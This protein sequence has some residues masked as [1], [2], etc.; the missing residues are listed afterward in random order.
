MRIAYDHSAFTRQA[1]G[2][3][4]RYF[5][6]L[7]QTIA[8]Y[9]DHKINIIAPFHINRHLHEVAP[10]IV[11]GHYLPNYP[12]ITKPFLKALNNGMTHRR[13]AEWKPDV[14]HETYFTPFPTT[15]LAVPRV[16]TIHDMIHEI[17]PDNFWSWDKTSRNKCIA[18]Q[19]ADHVICISE[20]TRKDLIQFFDVD[21]S[22]ISVVHHAYQRF[23]PPCEEE[24]ADIPVTPFI[25]FVGHRDGYKNFSAMMKAYATSVHIRASFNVICFGGGNFRPQELAWFE[26]L[27]I[28]GKVRQVSGRDALL[29]ALYSRASAFVYPSLYE[30]FGLPPLEAMAHDC[31]VVCSNTSS[32]PEVVADAGEY[33]DP[34]DID[35]IRVAIE[36][37]LFA[38]HE[39]RINMVKKGRER[40]N[41]F[42][43]RKCA[44]QTLEVYRNVI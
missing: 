3:V 31:I 34:Q 38:S 40:L 30:G 17:Y 25:L 13:L 28:R 4:S 21:T 7:A 1:F 23:D 42:S 44:E 10:Y 39:S 32:I 19:R 37:V 12:S 36:K 43:W 5:S 20:S 9:S 24:L 26:T 41:H 35:S 29:G 15:N 16:V 18:V 14:L 2:G 33:F 6:Q 8:A 22:K 27:G 11:S